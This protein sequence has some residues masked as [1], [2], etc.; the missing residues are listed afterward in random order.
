MRKKRI[1]Q[2]LLVLSVAALVA[3]PVSAYYGQTGGGS[4]NVLTAS[5]DITVSL[6]SVN[7]MGNTDSWNIIFSLSNLAHSNVDQLHLVVSWTSAPVV[8]MTLN[9]SSAIGPPGWDALASNFYLNCHAESCD[10]RYS[11]MSYNTTNRSVMVPT[12]TSATFSVTLSYI[13]DIF[14]SFIGFTANWYASGV[15]KPVTAS[16]SIFVT[17]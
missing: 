4:D 10:T 14:T 11:V 3:V 13:P 5:P 6:G 17:N 9:F 7:R 2:V 16:G 12:G 8:G 15:N 1:L